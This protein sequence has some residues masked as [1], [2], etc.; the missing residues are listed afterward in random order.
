M[1][2]SDFCFM[3]DPAMEIEKR[4]AVIKG[5]RAQRRN[6]RP[7][8]VVEIKDTKSVANLLSLTITEV[9]RGE[10]DLRVANCVGYLS[11]HLIK[12]L[13]ISDLGERV[14]ELEEVLAEKELVGAR[15]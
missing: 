8:P 2:D 14:T 11:G 15:E 6:R 4:N 1:T 5:G 3:H 10:V 9:R 13:E 7:L 12:A